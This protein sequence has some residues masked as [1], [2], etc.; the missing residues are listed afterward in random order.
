M[1]LALLPNLGMGGTATADAATAAITGTITDAVE[2]D[3]VAGGNTIVIT[4]ENDTW[5][6][7]FAAVRQAILD[8]LDS[9]GSEEFGWNAEVRDKEDVSAVVRTSDTVVTITLSAAADYAIDDDETITVTVPSTAVDGGAEI[10]ATPTFTIDAEAAA[11]GEPRGSTRA[12]QRHRTY[13]FGEHY[14]HLSKDDKRRID[15]IIQALKPEQEQ[16]LAKGKP[17]KAVRKQISRIIPEYA[18]YIPKPTSEYMREAQARLAAVQLAE[19]LDE[20][21]DDGTLLM[22][23]LLAA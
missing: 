21:A 1:L 12:D 4:L 17:S 2:S 13:D 19:R 3:I 23:I 22:L 7:S 18:A 14:P 11:R 9:D 8:G 10:T 15:D 6:S 5:V 20:Q 16:R